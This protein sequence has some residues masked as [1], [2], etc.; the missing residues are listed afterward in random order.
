MMTLRRLLSLAVTACLVAG[1]AARVR[2]GVVDTPLPTFAD[3][4][5]AKFAAFLPTVV[6]DNNL[7]TYVV[8]TNLG[9]TPIDVGRGGFDSG[10]TRGNTIA[11]GN[12]ALLNVPADA[13]VTFST[14]VTVVLHEEVVVALE[15]PVTV[16]GQGSGRVVST[17]LQVACTAYA[18]DRLHA[19]RDP[20]RSAERPP[21]ISVPP[22]RPACTPQAC[23]DATPCTADGCDHAGVCTHAPV[24]NGTPC[25]DAN[26]CTTAD[27]CLAGQCVGSAISCDDANICT[28]DG[29]A[30]ASGCT[31]SP[32]SC[33]DGNPCTADSCAPASGCQHA[34]IAGCSTTTTT[35]TSTSTSSS[36]STTSTSSS[37]TSTTSTSSSSTTSTSTSTTTSTSGRPSDDANRCTTDVSSPPPTGC[38]HLANALT[39]TDGN[40]TTTGDSCSGG[41]CM[42][43]IRNAKLALNAGENPS[44]SAA[45]PAAGDSRTDGTSTRVSFI[46]LDP[47]RY[48]A[49]CTGVTVKVGA[50][51]GTATVTPFAAQAA[52]LVRATAVHFL[53]A[54]T[55]PAGS[56]VNFQVSC[57]VG[58][59]Q[60][61][62]RWQGVVTNPPACTPTT[63]AAQGKNCGAISDGCGGTLT[64]G[65]CTTPQTCGGAGV[66]NV[67]GAAP[68]TATLTV[69]AT[70][71]AGVS[72]VSTP[73]RVN[74]PVGTT[75]SAS[76]PVGTSITLSATN[77]RSVIWSGVCSSAGARTL[78]CTFTLNA[79]SSE[80][81]NVQ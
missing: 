41:K 44:L 73:A 12:G 22:V 14:G 79:A 63:C 62:T 75:G 35:S 33:D 42:G 59:V 18:V 50:I 49:G 71:R 20:V 51:S 39:C 54:G 11:A 61:L 70:G 52:S 34:A 15:L 55:V 69:T 16:L 36:S 1:P 64:C 13:T 24:A 37:T 27:A 23:A 65:A 66:A 9:T 30:P 7:R 47:A 72:V 4:Q 10:G 43:F 28:T 68:T 81:A 17:A 21:T 78:S 74:V 8:C 32:I 26:A 60:H 45:F 3:G 2:A 6:S 67:C 77:A 5:A 19:I 58:G 53:A 29:C 76:F 46:N 25:S 48:P 31:H 40:A 56:A 57:T 38:E 80:T